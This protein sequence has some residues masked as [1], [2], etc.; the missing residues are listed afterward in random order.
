MDTIRRRHPSDDGTEM[1]ATPEL[2]LTVEELRLARLALADAEA[3]ERNVKA[4]VMEAIGDAS[5]LV[6]PGFVISFKQSKPSAKVEWELVAKSYRGALED[7]YRAGPMWDV[8][9]GAPET[10]DAIETLYSS[11]TPGSRRFVPTWKGE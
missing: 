9:L 11:T 10:L 6:G 8:G 3:N 5:K 7:A 4:A 2:T 1:V